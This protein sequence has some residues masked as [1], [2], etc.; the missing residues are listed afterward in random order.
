MCQASWNFLGCS[1]T[2]PPL[3]PV[4]GSGLWSEG[5]FTLQG[6]DCTRLGGVM[7]NIRRLRYEAVFFKIRGGKSVNILYS[8]ESMD[9]KNTLKVT[10]LLV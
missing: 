1:I 4:C 8:S 6:R 2:V 7:G 9:S 5:I 10:K 3:F